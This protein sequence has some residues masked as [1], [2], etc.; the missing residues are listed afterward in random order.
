MHDSSLMSVADRVRHLH[1]QTH[2]LLQGQSIVRG[3]LGQVAPFNE[4]EDDK[5]A[6]R[7][8]Q[9]VMHDDNANSPIELEIPARQRK[10]DAFEVGRVLPA[11]ARRMVGPFAFFDHMGPARLEPG[12]G[13]DP[14]IQ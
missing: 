10:L 3:K 4:L 5:D 9:H 8:S 2:D 14:T 6:F 1:H 11:P 7:V 12:L 13:M